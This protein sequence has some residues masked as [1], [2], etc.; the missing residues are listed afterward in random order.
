MSDAE[1]GEEEGRWGDG[2]QSGM[3]GGD[4]VEMG[5]C[6]ELQESGEL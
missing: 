5:R 2:R 1:M 4:A 3:T 6:E